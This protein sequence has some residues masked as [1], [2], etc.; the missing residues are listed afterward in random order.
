MP[1]NDANN[2]LS[3]NL[4]VAILLKR[5]DLLTLNG[6]RASLKSSYFTFFVL[7]DVSLTIKS[8]IQN[9][10]MNGHYTAM[11][12]IFHVKLI[13]SITLLFFYQLYLY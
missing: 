5:F 13:K 8:H 6:N 7:L 12:H 10:N 11:K 2:L 3:I 1:D 9:I 4:W